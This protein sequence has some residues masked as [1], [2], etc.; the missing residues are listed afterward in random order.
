MRCNL[1]RDIDAL[2]VG[3]LKLHYL[4]GFQDG[5]PINDFLAGDA[6]GTTSEE[7]ETYSEILMPTL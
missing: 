3:L 6:T 1:H 4:F 2:I 5:T 7:I